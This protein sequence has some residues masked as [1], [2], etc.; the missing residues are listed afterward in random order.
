MAIRDTTDIQNC[1]AILQERL[2]LIADLVETEE[3]TTQAAA[4]LIEAEN[5]FNSFK[6]EVS[7]ILG[8]SLDNKGDIDGFED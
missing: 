7:S 1:I 2:L 4:A 3:T 6:A 8:I 5:E